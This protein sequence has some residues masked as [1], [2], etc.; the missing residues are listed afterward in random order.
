ME[1]TG[2]IDCK[3][4]QMETWHQIED[5]AAMKRK[6]EKFDEFSCAYWQ[7]MWLEICLNLYSQSKLEFLVSYEFTLTVESR[8]LTNSPPVVCD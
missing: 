8:V 6:R 2:R 4:W 1:R 7:L 5:C 3:F